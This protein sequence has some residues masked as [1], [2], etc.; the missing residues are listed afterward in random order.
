MTFWQGI[1][2]LSP[3]IIGITAIF[4]I[5]YPVSM[6]AVHKLMGGKLTIREILKRI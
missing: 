4:G 3:Y 5:V 6:I 1:A 2:V